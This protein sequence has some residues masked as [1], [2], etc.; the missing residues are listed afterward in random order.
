MA[1][2]YKR[3]LLI[4][5][6]QPS[7][8][9]RLVKEADALVEYGY[10]VTVLYQYWNKWGT[11][12]DKK[13]L[14]KKKWAAIR[15]G[16]DPVHQKSIYLFTKLQFKVGQYLFKMFGPNNVLGELA[17][18]RCT[19]FLID[20]AA[21]IHAD[22]YIAHNLGAL[23]AAVK[24]AKK[25]KAKCGFDAE[26]FHRQESS[27]NTNSITFKLAKFIEDRYLPKL[28]YFTASSPLIAYKYQEI[29]P[30]LKPEVIHNVFPK[31]SIKKANAKKDG[32]QLFWFSQ[33]IGKG[34]GIED[35]IKA[36]GILKKEHI[37][38]Q[39]LGNIDEYHQNYFSNL[40]VNAG[41]KEHQIK[42]ISPVFS[43]EIFEIASN[44]DIG[45]ALEQELPLNRDICLTNKIFTYLTAGIAVVASET[46]SQKKFILENPTVGKSFAIGDFNS[47]SKIINA[48]DM[49]RTMLT[50]TK[51][52]ARILASEKYNW[53]NEQEKFI[54]IVEK[55]LSI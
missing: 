28:D 1:I 43:E 51:E 34:R 32:I 29:Y 26:D 16:G 18:G 54:Q 9:P 14:P 46:S 45:L 22:L 36:L 35:A 3:I 39:L 8:N 42:Y 48:Y 4:S 6:G 10:D 55:Q 31:H 13:L 20:K 7:L 25:F 37:C 44:C 50:L 23:P 21:K 17:I 53:E 27:D 5:S 40:A 12:F 19:N 30:E 24:A 15:I 52:N 11:D 49:D 33:T 41:L 2:R 47:L 38:I